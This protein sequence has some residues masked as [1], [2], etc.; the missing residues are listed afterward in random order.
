MLSAPV[1]ERRS[2]VG[3]CPWGLGAEVAGA[4]SGLKLGPFWANN[5]H[6]LCHSA[7]PTTAQPLPSA[8][9][10]I[11]SCDP[12]GRSIVEAQQPISL[13]PLVS[14][15][16][17]S[18]SSPAS[19][20]PCR[21]PA[22]TTRNSRTGSH[23]GYRP[24]VYSAIAEQ[25]GGILCH[26]RT[27]D[28]PETPRISPCHEAR[29][30]GNVETEGPTRQT[31]TTPPTR[32]IYPTA[33]S[34]GSLVQSACAYYPSYIWRCRVRFQEVACLGCAPGLRHSPM[35]KPPC[36][37]PNPASR[38]HCEVMICRSARDY[39]PQ[40][41]RRD[42]PRTLFRL[43]CSHGFAGPSRLAALNK[44]QSP[45]YRGSPSEVAVTQL[46]QHMRPA[47]RTPRDYHWRVAF[48]FSCCSR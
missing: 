10:H 48:C 15:R 36:L 30:L 1:G 44:R 17:E 2:T 18:C 47:G 26:F 5:F 8:S 41:F 19:C 6:P 25:S 22:T 14:N 33:R 4:V 45:L 32:S 28:Q 38:V 34:V 23:G 42:P 39:R 40:T 16:G 3:G 27:R 9:A 46:L 29:A 20:A 21:F 31:H 43:A 37:P 35:W 11:L 24:R 7:T 13:H 12:P